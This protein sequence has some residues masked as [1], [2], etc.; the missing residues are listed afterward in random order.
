MAAIFCRSEPGFYF[1][2]QSIERLLIGI[3]AECKKLDAIASSFLSL[4]KDSDYLIGV[5]V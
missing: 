3:L 1:F 2:R 4:V 5:F